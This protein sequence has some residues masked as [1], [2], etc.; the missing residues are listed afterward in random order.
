M[1]S[2][3]QGKIRIAASENRF[4]DGRRKQIVQIEVE[5]TDDAHTGSRVTV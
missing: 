3:R 4:A 5:L 1:H 2:A